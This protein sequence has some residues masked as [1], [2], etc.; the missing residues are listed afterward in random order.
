MNLE[1]QKEQFSRAYVQ[2]IAAT[3]GFAWSTMS[4]DDDSIDLTLHQ[5]RGRG[6]I[7]SPRIDLQLKC[8][9]AETPIA[10]HF[11]FKLKMKNYDDLRVE[12]GLLARL[13]LGQPAEGQ[14]VEI[15]QVDV[16]QVAPSAVV[17]SLR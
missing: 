17:A 2:A 12:E 10:E 3:A 1:M 16:A 6:L 14:G 13:L 8:T 4:V 9:A 15:L 7:S 5:R 11:S